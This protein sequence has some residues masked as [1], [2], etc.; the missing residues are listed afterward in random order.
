MKLLGIGLA[1]ISLA[2]KALM[3][4]SVNPDLK[5]KGR[6]GLNSALLKDLLSIWF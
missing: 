4:V 3:R 5:N 2:G 1:M 6:V